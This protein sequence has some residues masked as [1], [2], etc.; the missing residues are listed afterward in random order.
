MKDI[1][2]SSFVMQHTK[3]F[4]VLFLIL[5]IFGILFCM[6][7]NKKEPFIENL[8]VY[9]NGVQTFRKCKR[10]VARK[11][12]KNAKLIKE[13]TNRYVRKCRI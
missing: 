9:K 12:E 2:K 11:L 6:M 5:S 7:R 1:L 8:E 10:E 3:Q 13:K 4:L